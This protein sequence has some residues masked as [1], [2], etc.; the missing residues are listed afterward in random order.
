MNCRWDFDKE[1]WKY[2]S[3][4]AKDF[5]SHLIVKDPTER[6]S[7][8]QCLAHPWLA[9]PGSKDLRVPTSQKNLGG[10]LTRL[11]DFTYGRKAAKSLMD[12]FEKP[13]AEKDEE[14]T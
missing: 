9:P 11:K 1:E 10:T 8:V 3:A 13:G 6:M 5:I 2:V 4:D 7:A 12:L 14:K